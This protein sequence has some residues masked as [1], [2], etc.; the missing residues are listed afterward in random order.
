MAQDKRPLEA[1]PA[2][3]V[4]PDCGAGPFKNELG[5]RGHMAGKHRIKYESRQEP[6]ALARF[7]AK[8]DKLRERT[9][10][11]VG[12]LEPWMKLALARMTLYGLPATVVLEDMR[13][14]KGK[15]LFKV[16]VK[17]PG[18]EAYVEELEKIMDDPGMVMK[19][20]MT[21]SMLNIY[22]GW[23]LSFQ[24]AVE[25]RDHKLVH[26]MA[27][28]IGLKPALAKFQDSGPQT[29]TSVV[30]NL[31]TNDLAAPEIQTTYT[32]MDAELLDDDDDDL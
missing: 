17:S 29:P 27:R 26:Q 7:K 28:D 22:A 10:D 32:A 24:A 12:E 31:G 30:I 3:Y 14:G 16:V 4:C 23:M 13:D 11:T 5:F 8:M 9:F 2:D 20:L 21:D 6:K 1:I 19:N 25:Q 18:A 15:E